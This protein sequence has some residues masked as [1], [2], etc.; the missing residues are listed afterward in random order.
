MVAASGVMGV[1]LGGA[2]NG[3]VTA[4]LAG[5]PVPASA[6]CRGCGQRISRLDR[7]CP[8]CAAPGPFARTVALGALGGLL[9]GTLAWRLGATPILAAEE[10][11]ALGLLALSAVDLASYRLPNRLLYPTAALVLLGEVAAA[12]AQGQFGSL[13]RAVL[14]GALAFGIF[15]LIH[16]VAPR[17]MG[18]GDV[19]LAGLVGLG[20]GWFGA[21][22]EFSAFFT[23]FV[24]GA[25]VGLVVMVVTGQGRR[26]RLPFGPFLAAGAVVALLA[27]GPLGRFL[28]HGGR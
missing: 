15:A 12:G 13:E 4:E 23:A 28:L 17:G 16:L 2:L 7:T 8:G 10:I 22:P 3:P 27:G 21:G 6:C 18:F 20:C 26:T 14:F 9:L 1:V 11:L 24:G 25:L 19:R 5:R